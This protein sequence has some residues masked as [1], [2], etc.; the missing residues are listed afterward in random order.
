MKMETKA[1]PRVIAVLL[2][3][4]ALPAMP[5]IAQEV[6]PPPAVP[7]TP[8]PAPVATVPV[9]PPPVVRTT[10]PTP[11]PVAT[12]PAAQVTPEPE[13]AEAPPPEPQATR[14]PARP[15]AE[16]RRAAPAPAVAEPVA[17]APV[18]ET[19][20]EPAVAPVAEPIA[21]PLAEA[22][23]AEPAPEAQ[24]ET[25]GT[26]WL[27]IAAALAVIAAAIAGLLLM[28]RRRRAAEDE[29]YEE[30]LY[31]EA[32]AEPAYE[33]AV[34]PAISQALAKPAPERPALRPIID[35]ALAA[36][37]FSPT[38]A[39]AMPVD[40]A[41]MVEEEPASEPA[42]PAERPWIELAMRPVRA[43]TSE[44]EAVVEFELTIENAGSVPA[45]DVKISTWMFSAS[46]AQSDAERMLLEPPVDSRLAALDIE[47]GAGKQMEATLAL[48]KSALAVVGSPDRRA[49]F[50][51][52]VV[53]DARY[54]LP[55]GGEGRISASFEI[56]LQSETGELAPLHVDGAPEL[57]EDI[58]A[59]LHGEL[60]RA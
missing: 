16:A 12:P 4:V 58:E 7:T 11:A 44:D 49:G 30:V 50:R 43:G 21:P 51:P 14:Q 20:A 57:R 46:P 60:E 38:L 25:G 28:R 24:P 23:A 40:Q 56:G 55:D 2:A 32:P 1:R 37:S 36:A 19:P 13:A 17:A 5:A 41:A 10:A 48:P 27:P 3:A 59:R 29:Y 47:P 22:P 52:V 9:T 15:R 18:T 6:A 31:E 42:A 33:P 26:A 39:P 53:A 35:P 34:E 8:A 45:E 54:P